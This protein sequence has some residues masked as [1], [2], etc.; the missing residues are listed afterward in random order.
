MKKSALFLVLVLGIG[1]GALFSV[2]QPD[3]FPH[4]KHAGLFPSCEGCHS[5]VTADD[6]TAV[7]SV[8]PET[9][10]GCHNGT[11]QPEVNWAGPSPPASNVNFSH[12]KHPPAPCALC[13]EMPDA[14]APMEIQRANLPSCLTCHAPG[15]EEHQATGVTCSKC[16]Q[17][18][19][20]AT[21]LTVDQ[22]A[23]FPQPSDHERDDF[24]S[25][26]SS[27]AAE[28]LAR[29]AVCHTRDSCQRCH[30]NGEQIS[31]IQDLPRDER[32]ASL[33]AD[34][35]GRWPAPA[36]HGRLDWSESHGAEANE[37]IG[38]C[39]NCHAQPSCETCHGDGEPV[40]IRELP[41][42]T[43][44]GPQGVMFAAGGPPGHTPD[45]KTQHRS[46]AVAG[47]PDCSTCHTESYCADCH[48]GP[49]SPGFHPVNFVARH[50]AE[51]FA[52]ETECST[53]HSSE[54]FCRDCHEGIGF[55]QGGRSGAAYH[56]AT[57]SWLIG[58]GRAARQD[59]EACVTC[60]QQSSCLR[61]HSAKDGWRV[62][63][64]GP[65]FD[66]DRVADRSEQ[67]CAICHFASQ[68][69]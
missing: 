15:A 16:H 68:L 39:A 41:V 12:S 9:C 40:V 3:R 25:T 66:P 17:S 57:D 35:P 33:A 13:H 55:A 14:A 18:L 1:G 44:D 54:A 7:Y 30:L 49:S 53:C 31:S 69:E 8:T 46:A 65:D 5:G 24:L 63:P 61:C 51:A 52:T 48:D 22:I 56:D 28:D 21:T 6:A 4:A 20:E 37:S 19:G 11:V 60:H 34:R 38:T 64:H 36:N 50:G 10:A 2:P 62:N 29:C 47:I 58:H 59:M 43:S 67:S 45:F 27:G 32:V 23:L 42:P 26:H